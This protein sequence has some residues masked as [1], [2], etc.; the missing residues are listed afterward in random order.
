MKYIRR[1]SSLPEGLRDALISGTLGNKMLDVPS[2]LFPLDGVLH[3]GGS[4]PGTKI[5]APFQLPILGLLCET[6]AISLVMSA[7]TLFKVLTM[8]HI[9]SVKGRAEQNVS[10]VGHLNKKAPLNR[11][12]SGEYRIRTGGLLPARQAL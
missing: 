8:A 4:C 7:Q 5:P 11:C 12:F 3:L 9:I 1:T 6:A 10:M 2:T